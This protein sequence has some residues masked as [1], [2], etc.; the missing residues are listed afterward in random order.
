MSRVTSHVLHVTNV[1][2][3][4]SQPTWL[5]SSLFLYLLSWL[6]I[7]WIDFYI[8]WSQR[9]V[10]TMTGW[11]KLF[12]E[13]E[14]VSA[15][16]SWQVIFGSGFVLKLDKCLKI[17]IEKSQLKVGVFDGNMMKGSYKRFL[18]IFSFRNWASWWNQMV[19]FS[20]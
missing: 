10:F 5:S 14:L 7:Y 11:W 20:E 13:F 2:W 8:H 3:K 18:G 15:L 6:A 9:L 4:M 16:I 19:N 12:L 17:S 1:K